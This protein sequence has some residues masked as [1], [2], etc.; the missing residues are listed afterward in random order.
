MYKTPRGRIHGHSTSLVWKY[1]E[2][3]VSSKLF[4][5]RTMVKFWA[6]NTMDIVGSTSWILTNLLQTN[7]LEFKKVVH[8][9]IS[10]SFKNKCECTLLNIYRFRWNQR[11]WEWDYGPLSHKIP[12][13]YIQFIGFKLELSTY[14][15]L[16]K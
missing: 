6:P 10:I 3:P 5:W 14:T 2:S 7:L 15:Y 12:T 1:Q 16:R 4:V 11:S 9:L 13:I 8:L